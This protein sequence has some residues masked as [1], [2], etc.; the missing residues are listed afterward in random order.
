MITRWEDEEDQED[1]EDEEDQ[2]DQED[3]GGKVHLCAAEDKISP[4]LALVWH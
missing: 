4:V 1:E 3:Q 2:E